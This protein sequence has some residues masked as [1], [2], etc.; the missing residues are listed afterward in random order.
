[1]SSAIFH[2]NANTKV[3]K[4]NTRGKGKVVIVA[5]SDYDKNNDHEND[6]KYIVD[7]VMNLGLDDGKDT[8]SSAV[9]FTSGSTSRPRSG[10]TAEFDESMTDS[11]MVMHG[12]DEVMM[13]EIALLELISHGRL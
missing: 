5:A 6:C 7:G 12:C 11:W 13:N 1:M 4:N 10:L 2:A 3:G 8:S 9:T